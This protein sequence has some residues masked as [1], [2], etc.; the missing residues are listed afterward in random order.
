MML[1]V[2]NKG[3]VDLIHNWNVSGRCR[4]MNVKLYFLSEIKDIIRVQH[5]PGEEN[6]SD[7]FTKNLSGPCWADALFEK[8]GSKW[9]G[10]DECCEHIGTDGKKD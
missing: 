4:H 7:I 10:V 1:H 5:Q 2:D 8:H 6:K 9:F 3:A